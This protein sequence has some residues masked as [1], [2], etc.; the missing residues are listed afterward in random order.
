LNNIRV[1]ILKEN[2][3]EDK[4]SEENQGLI[5][6]RIAGTFRTTPEGI[7]PRL[8]SYR[9]EGGAFIYIC[10]EQQSGQ[11]LKNAMHGHK[12]REGTTLRAIDTKDLPK[13]VKMSLRTGDKQS[14]DTK[15]LVQWIGDLNLGLSSEHWRVL[16]KQLE[17]KGQRLIL[18]VD[19]DS[20]SAIKETGYRVFTGLSEGIFKVLHDPED[21]TSRGRETVVGISAPSSGAEE[22]GT[23]RYSL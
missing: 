19:R 18:L 20:T 13:P 23:Y 1:A 14:T 22:G 2:Y 8:R 21:T 5:L 11:W 3:P 4:L 15:E 7:L 12:L 16:N 10:A 6:D 17:P 9:L